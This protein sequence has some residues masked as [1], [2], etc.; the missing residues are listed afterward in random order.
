[1]EKNGV[2]GNFRRAM[3]YIQG[4]D[5]QGLTR[6]LR[7]HR[8]LARQLA[9]D[10]MEI[11]HTPKNS[12]KPNGHLRASAGQL[13]VLLAVMR[14]GGKLAIDDI[15]VSYVARFEPTPD[16]HH[17]H[18]WTGYFYD[19]RNAAYVAKGKTLAAASRRAS[20]V[21]AAYVNDRLAQGKELPPATYRVRNDRQTIRQE[22]VSLTLADL[23]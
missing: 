21:L 14:A 23:V 8:E 5:Y 7:R 9:E 4:E 20:D 11:Y 15:A 22:R 13:S 17:P 2:N 3:Q 16:S 18:A 6:F 12:L 19:V 1:M 10:I